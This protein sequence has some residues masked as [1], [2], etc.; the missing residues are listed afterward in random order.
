MR[1]VALVAVAA[2]LGACAM[3]PDAP[4]DAVGANAL[5][6]GE[7]R[8]DLSYPGLR[9]IGVRFVIEESDDAIVGRMIAAENMGFAGGPLENLTV[10]GD[11][12]AFR[13]SL[14]GD[15][16]DC[17]LRVQP[18]QTVFG[19]C[20]SPMEPTIGIRMVPPGVD[21]PTGL[22]RAMLSMSSVRWV[23]V[24]RGAT[25]IRVA[26]D[27]R[28]RV[29]SAAVS[30][31]IARARELNVQLVGDSALTTP[32]DVFL[33]E[34]REQMRGIVGRPSGGTAD[35]MAGTV[36]ITSL[37]TWSN[38]LTHEVTHALTFIG[39]GPPHD[40]AGWLRE[41]LATWIAGECRGNAVH[42]LAR[43]LRRRDELLP[44]RVLVDDFQSQDDLIAYLES[45]SV[46]GYMINRYG[47]DAFRGVWGEGES[48]LRGVDLDVATLERDWLR[49]LDSR[50]EPQP[51]DWTALREGG[52]DR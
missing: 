6:L 11:S 3:Q 30:D 40:G 22:A 5:P 36:L 47:V 24:E 48:G 33:L 25:R 35:P 9:A 29:D 34:S 18:D 31:V 32:L 38:A 2:A 13:W 42:D 28:A 45:A 21:E 10:D 51:I 44:L 37:G 19:P 23:D 8:G 27:Q 46:I 17:A 4:Q 39:W 49:F 15:P 1:L 7:W 20:T 52:C 50:E 26:S 12:V 41:G 14:N 16:Y 43:D